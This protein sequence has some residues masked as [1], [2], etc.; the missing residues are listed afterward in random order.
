MTFSLP[1]LL[2]SMAILSP[3]LL[4]IA[5]PPR[6]TPTPPRIPMWLTILER[7]GQAGC[8]IAPALTGQ[9]PGSAWW[10]G[11]AIAAIAAYYAVWI[12]YFVSRRAFSA[13]YAPVGPLP[14]PLAV[15]P[16]VGFGLAAGWLGSW[17]AGLAAAVLAV[18]HIGSSLRTASAIGSRG[19]TRW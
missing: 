10:L 13:L 6:G 12:R 18:G 1:G 7:V 11:G 15:F 16:V 9:T 3:S 2:V 19:R 8:I 14:V 17:W 4:L 5:F